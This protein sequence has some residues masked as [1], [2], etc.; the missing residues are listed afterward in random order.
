MMKHFCLFIALL[1]CTLASKAAPAEGDSSWFSYMKEC[2]HYGQHQLHALIEQNNINKREGKIAA[3]NY[4]VDFSGMEPL[5]GGISAPFNDYTSILGKGDYKGNDKLDAATLQTLNKHLQELNDG[6]GPDIYVAVNLRLGLIINTRQISGSYADVAY[7]ST[8]IKVQWQNRSEVVANHDAIRTYF[9]NEMNKAANDDNYVLFTW[10]KYFE[11]SKKGNDKDNRLR[12]SATAYYNFWFNNTSY[13]NDIPAIEDYVRTKSGFHLMPNQTASDLLAKYKACTQQL[14]YAMANVS[15]IRDELADTYAKQLKD[16]GLNFFNAHKSNYHVTPDVLFRIGTLINK[17]DEQFL[18]VF[19]EE[20]TYRPKDRMERYYQQQSLT[21]E[22]F[23]RFENALKNHYEEHQ[24]LEAALAKSTDNEEVY[25]MAL[26]LNPLNLKTISAETRLKILKAI[27]ELRD[28]VKTETVTYYNL[29]QHLGGTISTKEIEFPVLA[30]WG[31]HAGKLVMAMLELAPVD[32]H[33]VLAAKLADNPALVLDDYNRVQEDMGK[34]HL[35]DFV[36]I[37]YTICYKDHNISKGLV[38]LS[39]YKESM[40][41]V[42][43]NMHKVLTSKSDGGVYSGTGT[44]WDVSYTVNNNQI[45][46]K[47]INYFVEFGGAAHVGGY[48]MRKPL[49]EIEVQISNPL[50]EVVYLYIDEPVALLPGYTPG[51][52][53]PIPAIALLWAIDNRMLQQRENMVKA[54]KFLLDYATFFIGLGELN[55][56]YKGFRL[57]WAYTEIAVAGGDIIVNYSGLREKLEKSPEG[58]AFLGAWDKFS[59]VVGVASIGNATYELGTQAFSAWKKHRQ[60]LK[61][62]LN[63]DEFAR[64]EKDVTIAGQKMKDNGCDFSKYLDDVPYASIINSLKAMAKAKL[65]PGF[66]NAVKKLGKTEDEIMEYFARYQYESNFF[67]LI[68]DFI[69]DPLKNVNKLSPEEAYTIWGYTTSL[70]YRE[71]NGMMRQGLD[72][73]KT[74]DMAQML[75]NA[76]KK[77]NPPY[78]GAVYRAIEIAPAD[79]NNFLGNYQDGMELVWKEFTSAGSSPTGS[80]Q[81][82]SKKNVIFEIESTFSGKDIT[83]LADGVKFRNM[84]PKEILFDAGMKVKVTAPPIFQADGKI[85]IKLK[86]IP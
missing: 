57:F 47:S 64:L 3:N 61:S 23:L 72:A 34:E 24:Q 56:A 25:R 50:K 4:V 63:A 31:N 60:A 5:N 40:Q 81:V 75:S 44:S 54:G 46:F 16:R 15:K 38:D 37:L 22:D 21:K 86:E 28:K 79:L 84:A 35:Y 65:P 55:A 39:K 67:D 73:A 30:D 78:N 71:M 52:A 27:Y 2:A 69:S 62:Q 66:V 53:Y 12:V 77:L 9:V 42:W 14:D 6:T 17:V 36:D 7:G 11:V 33:A 26:A 20:V 8:G 74:A 19:S 59:T 70:Y 68:E 49:N 1:A 48:S 41:L 10:G 29:P 83:D 85:L 32:Q 18:K 43:G 80:F 13:K 58:Q 51:R 45:Q 76:L 82:K